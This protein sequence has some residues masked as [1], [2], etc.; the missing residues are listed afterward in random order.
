[1]VL[2]RPD[3]G[4]A[5]L[6]AAVGAHRLEHPEGQIDYSQIFPDLFRRLRDHFYDERKRTLRKNSERILRFLGDER[7]QLQQRELA[8]VESTLASMKS[9]YGYCEH[10]A[11]DALVL[12]LTKRYND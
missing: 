2:R 4:Y 5:L 8:Q 1:M 10:C 9:R 3:L 11:K 6:R 7:G 12:L